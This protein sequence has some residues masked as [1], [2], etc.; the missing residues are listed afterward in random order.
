[1]IKKPMLAV[2]V[3]DLHDV[4]FPV[5]ATPKLDGIRCLIVGGKAVS[6]KLKPIPNNFIRQYLEHQCEEGWDGELIVEGKSFNEIQ[7]LV[8]SEDG[9][10]NF[11]YV[12]FDWFHSKQGYNDRLNMMHFYKT[13]RTLPDRVEFLFPTAFARLIHLLDYEKECLQKGY[14]GVMLRS[15]DGL[16]KFGRSTLKQGW[17]LKLKRF[18]DAEATVIGFVEKMHN[19]NEAKLDE[20]GHTKR[21]S[22]KENLIPAGTLGTLVVKAGDYEFGIGTG[23]DDEQRKTI[24]ENRDQYLGKLV[25]FKYQEVGML[26]RPRFPVFKGFR[27]ERDT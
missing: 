27:D 15:P 22:H 17:L 2:A 3:E 8:M 6:R 11:K 13:R 1:M 9:E 26:E 25:T 24:W 19:A 12:V 5:L 7:S 20:L 21:S 14:E 23:F 18:K 10:P 4:K 16:Y